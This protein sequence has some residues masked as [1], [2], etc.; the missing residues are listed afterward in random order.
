[1]T[2]LAVRGARRSSSKTRAEVQLAA[3]NRDR[4]GHRQPD[5]KTRAKFWRA[6]EAVNRAMCTLYNVVAGRGK[7]N[8]QGR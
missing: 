1:M 2:G 5:S 6:C 3:L 4:T 7:D 8:L